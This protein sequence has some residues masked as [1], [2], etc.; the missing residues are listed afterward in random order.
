MCFNHRSSVFCLCIVFSLSVF[1]IW[2]LFMLYPL[3]K[4]M[5]ERFWASASLS[6]PAFCFVFGFPFFY[7]LCLFPDV[8]APFITISVCLKRLFICFHSL[9]FSASFY[10]PDLVVFWPIRMTKIGF[11][12]PLIFLHFVL[13]H[14][15]FF[16]PF[17]IDFL[18]FQVFKN[19]I[20]NGSWFLHD[21]P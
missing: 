9:S 6:F 11:K 3:Y 14:L 12:F 18:D 21:S 19:G 8:L 10:L 4:A 13:I 7:F 5:L 15:S 16:I 20:K 1:L 17:L 2:I